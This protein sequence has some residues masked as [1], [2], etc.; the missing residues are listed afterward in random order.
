MKNDFL[1]KLY[2]TI[3]LVTFQYFGMLSSG[4]EG[5]CVWDPGGLFSRVIP[6][7]ALPMA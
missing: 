4:M 5:S 1:R 2:Y 6:S 3:I 7:P